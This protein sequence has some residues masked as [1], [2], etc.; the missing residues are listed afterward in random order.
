M[1]H[2]EENPVVYHVMT[3]LIEHGP[4]AMASAFATIMNLAMQIERQQALN[5][6]SHQRTDDRR[7]YANSFKPKTIST[8]VSEV[9]LRIL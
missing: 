5:A 1:T 4:A 6:D 9:S 7:G 2:Q 8:R 3:L